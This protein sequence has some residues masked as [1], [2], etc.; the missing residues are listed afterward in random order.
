MIRELVHS[1]ALII[2]DM[3]RDQVLDHSAP[4]LAAQ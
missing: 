2:I 3:A 1:F 4:V